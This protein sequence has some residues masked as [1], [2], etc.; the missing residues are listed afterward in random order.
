MKAINQR[1]LGLNHSISPGFLKLFG[2]PLIAGRDIDERDRLDSPPVVLISQATAK[3]L[4]PGENPIGHQMFFGVDKGTGLL[5]EIVGI[6]GDIRSRRLDQSDDV[7]FY[8]PIQQRIFPFMIATVRSPL[9]ASA[10]ATAVRAALNKIDPELPMI[11][12][13]P[14]TQLMSDS[15][16]QQRLSTTLLGIFAS[17]ALLLALIGIYG[18]VAHTVV[19]RRGEIGVRMALGAQTGGC[20]EDGDPAGNDS[21]GDRSGGRPWDCLDPGTSADLAAL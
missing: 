14:L 17:V 1:P 11:Q 20:I 6:V 16:G 18:A 2:I 8:R 19:Q 7:E 13:G 15:L 4:F 12:P 21:G 10:T 9:P 5:T 3:R